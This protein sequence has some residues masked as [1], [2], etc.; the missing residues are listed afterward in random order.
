MYNCK[1][2]YTNAVL[3]LSPLR[4]VHFLLLF[5]RGFLNSCPQTNQMSKNEGDCIMYW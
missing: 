1:T 2:H 4:K 5:S 3:A